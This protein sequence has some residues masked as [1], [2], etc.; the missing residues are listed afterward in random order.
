MALVPI[1]ISVDG[2][3][4]YAR[5]FDL[6]AREADDLR[7]PLR[8]V[9]AEL[10]GAISRQFAS[11]GA[12]ELGTRWQPLS[13]AYAAWKQANYPGRPMLVRT[14]EMRSAAV[15]AR[16]ALTITPR[17]LT[18]TVDSDYAIHHHRGEGVPSRRFVVLSEGTQ[19]NI[20]RVFASWLDG[21][22]K[23]PLWAGARR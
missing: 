11:E 19:R 8:D 1:T 7:E 6:A 22:F 12:S 3:Q 16:R 18:Y 23:G 5:A 13:P 14:G 20:D 21:V 4:A 17:R 9:G 15:D 10:I 2:E